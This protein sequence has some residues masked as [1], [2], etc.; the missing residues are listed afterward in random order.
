MG[1]GLFHSINTAI[2]GLLV[3]LVVLCGESV[4][5]DDRLVWP[6]KPLGTNSE[7]MNWYQAVGEGKLRI[8]LKVTA[9]G[10][11]EGWDYLSTPTRFVE[12]RSKVEES[13]RTWRFEPARTADGEPVAS[14]FDYVHLF[15]P[16]TDY[17]LARVF[18]QSPANVQEHFLA[19][20]KELKIKFSKSDESKGVFISKWIQYRPGRFPGFTEHEDFVPVRVRL[21]VFS[22]QAHEPARVYINSEVDAEHRVSREPLFIYNY[23]AFEDWLFN[24]LEDRLET[25]GSS[26]PRSIA[27][28]RAL[29]EAL[30]STECEQAEPMLAGI[31]D[32]ENPTLIEITKMEPIY[33]PDAAYDREAAQVIL[34]A[35]LHE[36]GSVGD[37]TVLKS[38]ARNINFNVAAK[39]TI[40]FW[41]YEAARKAGCPVTVYFTVVVDFLP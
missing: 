2:V 7:L 8:R 4:L 36:D 23:G 6:P 21:H 15:S 20:A 22:P 18:P 41:R 33:P 1:L 11:V 3:G 13:V 29:F 19:L 28:R 14:T 39:N 37:V 31:E 32:V 16:N 17:S 26:I 27:T 12:I 5:A 40:S 9:T 24:K 34:Q 30:G 35:I 38:N 10:E 25:R